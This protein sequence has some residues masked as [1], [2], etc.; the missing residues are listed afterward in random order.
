[1]KKLN[2]RITTFFK[3]KVTQEIE[4]IVNKSTASDWLVVY[5]DPKS[6]NWPFSVN[7]NFV[8][9]HE[10][11]FAG[12]IDIHS[13]TLKETVKLDVVINLDNH[14]PVSDSNWDNTITITCD[15]CSYIKLVKSN[16]EETNK[17]VNAAIRKA[18]NNKIKSLI[19]I[20]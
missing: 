16:G 5:A 3:S 14:L 7:R 15:F 20:K 2:D 18:I 13:Q 4:T 1:M 12:F 8:V 17:K 9:N 19:Q 6:M 11:I 10:Q